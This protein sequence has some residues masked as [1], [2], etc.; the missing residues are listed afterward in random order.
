MFHGIEKGADIMMGLDNKVPDGLEPENEEYS[1]MKE[2]IKDEKK[3]R[4]K[5]AQ[6]LGAVVGKGLV[7]GLAACISF[8]AAKPLLENVFPLRTQEV[9][10]PK[11]EVKTKKE[12]KEDEKKDEKK[13]ELTA[14]DYRELDQSLYY[15][16]AAVSKSLAEV[17][18]IKKAEDWMTQSG[19][20][21]N[22]AS[23]L[24]V[25]DNGQEYLILTD[26]SVLKDIKKIEVSFSDGSDHEA[27]LKAK[28]E[29]LGLGVVGVRKNGISES[30]KGQIKVAELGNSHMVN[31]GE[32]II[33]MGKPFAYFGGIGY[34]IVGS[35]KNYA[36]IADG[37]HQL[38]STDIAGSESGTGVLVNV[39]GQVVGI[40]RPSVVDGKNLRPLNALA[41]SGIKDEIE[42]LIN[43]NKVPY[44]GIYGVEVSKEIAARY[45]M[46]KGLYV[47]EVL[48]DS[49][50]MEAGI[51]C[52][53]IITHMGEEKIASV[54]SFHKELLEHQSGDTIYV[55]GRRQGKNQYETID[56][57]VEIGNK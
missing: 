2:S 46:P 21:A 49:P 29:N 18:G 22:S 48:V 23:G 51:Q 35:T 37:E 27:I 57:T 17:R 15:V 41:L 32:T 45:D 38:L 42:L 50:A 6:K 36:A 19:E 8:Y 25:G 14:L 9:K 53:D 56:F 52:G 54:S 10:I 4:K 16:T 30:T 3:D 24:I 39:E 7:F 34:G 13:Q 44:L 40:F 1:F 33:A 55:T 11:D 43:G 20:T 12:T 28:D 47:K 5:S 31:K 26:T